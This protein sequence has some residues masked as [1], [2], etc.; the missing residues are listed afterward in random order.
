MTT[1]TEANV[2]AERLLR[3]HRQMLLVR[4][5]EE[6]CERLYKGG[7]IRGG[8]HLA[9]GQEAVSVGVCENL[10]PDDTLT[11]TYRGHASVIAKGAPLDRLFGELLGRE[12]GCCRGKGGSMHL[13]DFNV[14]VLG[15]FAVVGAHLP[16]SAGAALTAKYRG[17][18]S[19]SACFF[20]D[21]A[22]NIG[23][24]HE[25]LNMAAVW[26]LPVVFVCENN[27]WGEYS[28][29]A[30]TTSTTRLVERGASYGI[31]S[32]RVDG[33]DVDAVREVAQEAI[34][35]ARSG[36]GPVFIEAMTYRQKGHSARSDAG[37]PPDEIASWLARD[38]IVLSEARLR[39][40]GV[41]S[42]ILDEARSE[43][44]TV[45]AAALAIAE[46]WAEPSVAELHTDVYA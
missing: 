32:R 16:V 4:A 18:D 7:S 26:K 39:E 1:S 43:A 28:P 37:R 13:T 34:G 38:P 36:E 46:S 11:C 2:D 44:E 42:A 35:V 12:G 27:L 40:Y 23:T 21:G 24:F 5:F 8:L 17:K 10:R 15:S 25:T 6:Q 9:N 45:V 14:G 41:A 19:V 30:S 22:T 29:I 33:N 3:S 20:G 31:W